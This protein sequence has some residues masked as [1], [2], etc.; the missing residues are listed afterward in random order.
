MANLINFWENHINSFK[1]L[2]LQT[3]QS[4][5]YQIWVTIL[6][7]GHDVKLQ[8][9]CRT[10]DWKCVKMADLVNV[11]ENHIHSFKNLPLQTHQSECNQ[12]WVTTIGQDPDNLQV[13]WCYLY[14]FIRMQLA[15]AWLH[16]LMREQLYR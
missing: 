1:N 9:L 8:R 10:H 11:W 7:Q 4:E 6:G 15:A 14:L 16:H 13:Q 2:H 5:C 12:I 3:Q